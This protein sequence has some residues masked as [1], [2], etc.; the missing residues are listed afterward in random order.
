[1][2]ISVDGYVAKKDGDSDW[3]SPVDSVNFE[4]KIKETGC[5]I[6]GRR[7][8]DQYQVLLKI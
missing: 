5:L 3:V 7:T 8:F 2:A 4:Q 1:M 6:V